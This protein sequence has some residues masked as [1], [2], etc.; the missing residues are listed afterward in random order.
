MFPADF[1]SGSR[2]FTQHLT[3]GELTVPIRRNLTG[4]ANANGYRT[5][6]E[7]V[8]ERERNGYRRDIERIQ[9]GYRT[10]TER[11]QN[12]NGNACRTETERVLSN[13]PC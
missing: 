2:D 3:S 9:N 4:N 11:I 12:G 10:D 5:D 1:I 6:T 13:V 7:Q 8:R